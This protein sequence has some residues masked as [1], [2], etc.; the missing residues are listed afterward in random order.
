MTLR[1]RLFIAA[2]AIAALAIAVLGVVEPGYDT[3]SDTVSR[4]GGPGSTHALLFNVIV[5]IYGAC[6]I[7]AATAIASVMRPSRVIA[8]LVALHGLA[9]IVT[10]AFPKN[11]AL[12]AHDRENMIHDRAA[13]IAAGAVVAAMLVV[14]LSRAPR[15]MRLG[16]AIAA[17]VVCGCATAFKFTSGTEAYG[18]LE[19]LVLAVAMV[20]L[21]GLTALTGV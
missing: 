9:T 13:V 1:V 18:V 10:A 4:L 20:W 7:S 6:A 5:C 21:V 2:T 15:R 3:R 19:R 17:L 16:S 14:A 11:V 12:G 8:T